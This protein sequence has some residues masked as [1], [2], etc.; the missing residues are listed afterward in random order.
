VDYVV[1]IVKYAIPQ[2]QHYVDGVQT[3]AMG[4]D[5]KTSTVKKDTM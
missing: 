4:S 5:P 3:I 1:R 2:N